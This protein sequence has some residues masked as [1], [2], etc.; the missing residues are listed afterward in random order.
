MRKINFFILILI[1]SMNS[2]FAQ[3]I[4]EL[5]SEKYLLQVD[6][7]TFQIFFGFKGSLEIEIGEKLIENPKLTSMIINPERRSLEIN[8]EESA[9]EGP[10]G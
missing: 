6:D 9:Y 3:D 1:P 4:A 8:F 5:A 10:S 2:V 7:Q